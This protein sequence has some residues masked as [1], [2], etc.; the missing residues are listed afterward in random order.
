MAAKP[1]LNDIHRAF[2]VRELA[3]Y[4]TP[5]QA[6]E[7]LNQC[8]GVV[9]SPQA[10]ERYHPHKKKGIRLAQKWV[11]LFDEA[12][13]GELRSAIGEETLQEFLGGLLGNSGKLLKSMQ[14]ALAEGDLDAARKVA[15]E[16]KGMAG[17]FCASRVAA[18]AEEIETEAPTIEAAE[19]EAKYLK[20]AIEQTQQWLEQTG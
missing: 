17:N 6:V 12:R 8:F 18:I 2:I 3:C 19:R 11:D 9:I 15:H 7:A 14:S 1:K 16:L 20:L 13:L 10:T 4:A 5:T